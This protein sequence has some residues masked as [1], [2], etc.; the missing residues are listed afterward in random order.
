VIILFFIFT[1]YYI[2]ITST[3]F[4]QLNVAVT[5]LLKLEANQVC[6]IIKK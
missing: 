3:N 4:H 5:V 1:I 6:I 2:F